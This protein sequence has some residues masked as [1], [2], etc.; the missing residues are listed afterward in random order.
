MARQYGRAL[1]FQSA[2]T[3]HGASTPPLLPQPLQPWPQQHT[4]QLAPHQ[5]Q[6]HGGGGSGGGVAHFPPPGHGSAPLLDL[7]FAAPGAPIGRAAPA[8]FSAAP[9]G[10]GGWELGGPGGQTNAHKL[11]AVLGILDLPRQAQAQVQP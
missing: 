6:F 11:R 10:G 4:P 5:L 3:F 9:Y 8:L 7:P 2:P 1:N